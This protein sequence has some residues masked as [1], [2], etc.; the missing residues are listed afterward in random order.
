[1]C[2]YCWWPSAAIVER[3]CSAVESVVGSVANSAA[4]T[5][6]QQACLATPSV[7]ADWMPQ[8]HLGS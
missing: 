1:M 8:R 4:R 2:C 6:G 3:L 5:S 7:G